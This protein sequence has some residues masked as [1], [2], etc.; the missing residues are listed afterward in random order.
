MNKPSESTISRRAMMCRTGAAFAASAVAPRV[1]AL[2]G[3]TTDADADKPPLA[4]PAWYYQH[5]DADF[6]LETPEETF[7]GWKKTELDFSREHTAV[8][9]MHAWDAGSFEEFPGWWRCVPYIPR[10]NAIMKEIFPGLLAAVRASDLPLFHVVGGGDYYKGLPGY[11]HA[12]ALAGPPAP[13]CPSVASD[14][15]RDKLARFRSE[16]VFVGA[17][18]AADVDRGFARLGFPEEACPKEDEGVAENGAQLFAL[19]KE[20]GINHLV[21][22][23]FAIN[24]CLLLSPGGMAD[25]QRYGVMCSA[26]RQATVAVENKETARFQLC[27]EV[28]LWR[29][30]LAFGFVFDVDDFVRA[31]QA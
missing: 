11:R 1:R 14:P 5:F 4:I 9:V 24:W 13:E 27:K 19:C 26:L 17:H 16:H 6:A 18:N 20:R 2:A 21:Y 29:V 30:A 31:I 3:A 8:V 25:M 10:A 15:I 28:A 7:G 12:L 23:G 22:C